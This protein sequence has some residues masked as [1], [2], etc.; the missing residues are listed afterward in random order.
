MGDNSGF[1]IIEILIAV[2]LMAVGF[3]VISNIQ[4]LSLNSY[5][6]LILIYF[7]YVKKSKK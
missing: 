1:T 6:F 4:F 5:D 7:R 2:F 3:L